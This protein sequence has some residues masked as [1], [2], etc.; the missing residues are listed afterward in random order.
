MTTEFEGLEVVHAE[1]AGEW[2]DWL[3]ASGATSAAFS[4][5]STGSRLEAGR[6]P[7]SAVDRER[8][9]PMAAKGST[10]SARQAVIDHARA[11]RR[12]NVK[13]G[14]EN[15]TAAPGVQADRRK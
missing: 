1:T 13:A 14:P 11:T 8:A 4:W 2:R 5:G 15:N 10:T 12:W 3:A 9:E 6:A 7:W